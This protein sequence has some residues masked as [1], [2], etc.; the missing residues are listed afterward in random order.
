MK[1]ISGHW[2]SYNLEPSR[3]SVVIEV[4]IF[5][6]FLTNSR[7]QRCAYSTTNTNPRHREGGFDGAIAGLARLAVP[8]E[9]RAALGPHRHERPFCYHCEGDDLA[10][11][12]RDREVQWFAG[13]GYF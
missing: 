6:F 2:R 7:P 1:N 8:A 3:S 12:E 13:R 4:R 10:A 9:R 11:D 5:S